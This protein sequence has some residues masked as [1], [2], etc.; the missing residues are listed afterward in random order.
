MSQFPFVDKEK[1]LES[2]LEYFHGF[3]TIIAPERKVLFANKPLVE[4]TGY[5]PVGHYCYKAFHNLDRPCSFCPLEEVLAKGGTHTWEHKSPL[6]NRWYSVVNTPIELPDGRKGMFCIVIDVHEKTLAEKRGERHRLLFETIWN[7]AP[8]MILGIEPHTGEIL[9]ANKASEK[10]LGYPP[11]ELFGRKVFELISPEEREKAFK[12]C[13]QICQGEEK[14][15][16]EF[17]WITK[18]GEKR[19]LK[20]SC[21][22]VNI[23]EEGNIIFNVARDITREKRL[24]EQLIQ[25]QKMEAVG[26]LAGG[27]AHD[28]N[29]LLT[30]MTSYLDLLKAHKNN[31]E[32]IEQ[33]IENIKLSLERTSNI[34]QKLLTFSG[35]HP[36]K[37]TILDI[38]R[39]LKDM[40]EFWQRLVG[41]NIEVKV[42]SPESEIYVQIDD[43][44]L[45]QII[46][47]LVVNARDAMPEGG[48][49]TIK[50]EIK[51]ADV[52][53]F[54]EP[55]QD[56][57]YAVLS[58]TD[59]GT[60]IPEEILPHIFEPFFTTKPPGKGTGLGLAM[61][62]SLV[63]QYGGHISVYTEKGKGTTFKLYFPVSLRT[64]KTY[65]Q[66]QEKSFLSKTEKQYNILVVEDDDLVREP[67][68]ELLRSSGYQV[69]AASDGLAALEVLTKKKFDLVI[70][71]LIMPKMGGEKLAKKIKE[72]Y[73]DTKIIL[74]SGYP[75]GSIPIDGKLENIAF[76]SK[77]YSFSQLLR[78]IHEV[79]EI[80]S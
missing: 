43:T 34:T 79:L 65:E 24:S 32:K 55:D 71:D 20:S 40:R 21:F 52:S 1:L 7:R 67:I 46:M 10:I 25:A 12:C 17:S 37:S 3:L 70:S 11:H 4:R 41:E 44:H 14:E 59:S 61:V 22:L 8:L 54:N 60:G 16:L 31:P 64:Q 42:F 49:L 29:N 36:Q 47:N 2:F 35:K 63:K 74:A 28:F 39:F 68:V 30:S 19:L 57:I 27:L 18:D 76:V 6:D 38:A 56:S 15:D 69:E 80:D 73:P 23:P 72:L 5:N 77:P 26:R 62:Y 78:K 9:L 33:I 75:E 45:Q 50:L 58:I 53:S 66:K 48:E 13:Q 51:E